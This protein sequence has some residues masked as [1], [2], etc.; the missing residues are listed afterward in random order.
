MPGWLLFYKMHVCSITLQR[1]T[2]Y[3]HS[4]N[5]YY[6]IK[7]FMKDTILLLFS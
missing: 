5:T 4:I 6:S 3:T 7:N 2:Q 1:V